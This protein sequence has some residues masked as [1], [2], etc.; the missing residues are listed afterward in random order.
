[1]KSWRRSAVRGVIASLVVLCLQV[2][3]GSAVFADGD[4]STIQTIHFD[5]VTLSFPSANPCSGAPGTLT[6]TYSGVFHQATNPTGDV[7][8]TTTIQGPFV[9]VPTDPTQ[10][11]YTGHY[12]SW[13]GQDVN[14]QNSVSHDTLNLTG[15]G[16][17]GSHLSF[18]LIDHASV[19]A[20]GVTLTFSDAVCGG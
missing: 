5:N 18:H 6:L 2:V 3:A 15:T 17:D 12:E 1:M 20:S 14:N 13:D 7:H 9:F 10:P 16:S 4:G 8:L 11:T 19:S